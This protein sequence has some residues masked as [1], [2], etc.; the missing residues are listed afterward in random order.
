MTQPLL[1][2]RAIAGRWRVLSLVKGLTLCR[3]TAH[4]P[5]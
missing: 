1:Q 3:P 2:V 5:D 4:S